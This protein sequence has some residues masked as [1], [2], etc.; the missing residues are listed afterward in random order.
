M[1]LLFE[2]VK[3]GSMLTY[4]ISL[5]NSLRSERRGKTAFYYTSRVSEVIY[6][7]GRAALCNW[8]NQCYII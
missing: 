3:T 4:R 5:G 7:G 1:I 6:K 8:I 2:S